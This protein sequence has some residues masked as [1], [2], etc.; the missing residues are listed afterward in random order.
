[1]GHVLTENHNGLVIDTRL[2][3]ANGTAEREATLEMLAELPDEARKTVGADN[4]YDIAP[5][6]EGCREI[7]VTPHVA[8]NTSR[9][10]SCIDQRT[11]RH[12][13]YLLSQFARKLIETV[14]GDVKQHGIP[15]H[16]KLR[17]LA[18][19]ELL[20]TLAATGVNLRRLP[21]LL[22]PEPSG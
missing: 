20:L 18:N 14:F 5:F 2:T 9:Q 21:K 22:A 7:M 3:Q 8:Q 12:A 10:R 16:V 15:R 17:G 13:G 19:V 1:M 11:T 6:V 4:A